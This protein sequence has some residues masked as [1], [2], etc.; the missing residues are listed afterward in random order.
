MLKTGGII[1]IE[2]LF[3]MYRDFFRHFPVLSSFMTCHRLCN[4]INTTGA[5]SGV[6]TAY[7]CRTPEFIPGFQWGS[8][9]S[10]FSFMYM[11]CR[12]LFVLFLLTIVLS[13]LFRFKDSNYLQEYLQTLLTRN[14]HNFYFGL[15][16]TVHVVRMYPVCLY[17]SD[18][19]QYYICKEF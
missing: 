4:Q 7:P 18:K 16:C 13:V 2:L 5:T 8:C 14:K 9:Y 11:F 19:I 15:I 12:L 10:I 6:G 3:K 1:L 17:V